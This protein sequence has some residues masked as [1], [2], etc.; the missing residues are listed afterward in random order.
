[1]EFGAAVAWGEE[2]GG[3]VIIAEVV[4]LVVVVVLGG[5]HPL[6]SLPG[7]HVGS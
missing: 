6:I 4:L 1:M 7:S 2:G 3:A 5:S